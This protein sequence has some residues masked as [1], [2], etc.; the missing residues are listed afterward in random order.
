MSKELEGKVAIVTGGAAGIGRATAVAF[1]REGAKVVVS[2]VT[3]GGGEG[4]V[5]LI[6]MAGGT[7]RCVPCDVSK[8][9]E[10][11]ALVEGTVQVERD[12]LPIAQL[13]PGSHFGEM[14]LLNQKPRS[15]TVTA[16]DE[17]ALLCLERTSFHQLMAHE[18]GIA[19]KFLWKFAQT[20]SL[21]LDDAYLARDFR[22]GRDTIGLGEYPSPH[23][24]ARKDG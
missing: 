6:R 4:T 23:N 15:A 7:A 2:D 14:A 21:R 22:K 18:P 9:Q 16:L 19:T 3:D 1:A 8:P 5:A 11:R 12:K 10:V 24:T 13:G 20:L 17:T